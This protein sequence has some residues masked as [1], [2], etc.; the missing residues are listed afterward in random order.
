MA[1]GELVPDETVISIIA[2]RYDLP[3][4]KN[5][6]VFDGFPRTVPQAEALDVML[7][8]RGRKIDLV[9]ELK[10]DDAVLLARV[11]SPD[12]GRRGARART[13]RR[14]PSGTGWR[15]ITRNTAPLIGYYKAQ[16]K[17]RTLDGMAPITD[18]TR[19]IDQA[20]LGSG[21]IGQ[22]RQ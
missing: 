21:L 8:E 11:E 1:K 16:G 5:G 10:V 13:T 19:Q 20:W 4:C 22:L 12:Q 9:L 7:K 15:S 17:L 3:D 14:K 18:V 2:E 6:A